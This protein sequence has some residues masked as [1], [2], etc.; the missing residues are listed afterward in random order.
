[1]LRFIRKYWWLIVIG[2]ILLPIGL[3]YLLNVNIGANIIGEPKDWLT[4]WGTYISSI[5]S[6]WMIILT[7]L[8]I[9]QNDEARQGVVICKVIY[10]KMNYGLEITNVG[11][12]VAYDIIISANEEFNNILHELTRK[13]FIKF[14]NKK[15]SLKPNESKYILI[16]CAVLGDHQTFNSDT[17]QMEVVNN[18]KEY[19]DKLKNT[20]LSI[21]GSYC[22]IGTKYEIKESFCINDFDL[23]FMAFTTT[24]DDELP[25]ITK[26]IN[27]IKCKV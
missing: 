18:N 6:L 14:Q 24:V 4:F 7:Y 2:F 23:N 15:F 26:A 11:N 1:M 22:S 3:N 16:E 9:K 19:L 17:D 10:H 5:A 20:T 21:E 8:I 12:S 27:G 13:I 25:K